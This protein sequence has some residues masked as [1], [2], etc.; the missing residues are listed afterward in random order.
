MVKLMKIGLFMFV[1]IKEIFLL[2]SLDDFINLISNQNFLHKSNAFRLSSQLNDNRI[3]TDNGEWHSRYGEMRN[4]TSVLAVR[5]H[6][7][8]ICF[9]CDHKL[10][11]LVI[12]SPISA[13]SIFKIKLLETFQNPSIVHVMR[14]D[15]TY[16]FISFSFVFEFTCRL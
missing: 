9:Q 1:F 2:N 3:L 4:I 5:V 13:E 14:C 6:I 10:F 8:W 16:L 11:D 15:I 12:R 7:A